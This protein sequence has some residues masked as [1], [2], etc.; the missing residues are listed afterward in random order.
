MLFINYRCEIQLLQGAQLK[1]G[2]ESARSRGQAT[3]LRYRWGIPIKR[4]AASRAA[5][6]RCSILLLQ[7]EGC[8]S[9][10]II[11]ST[12]AHH[13]LFFKDGE[14]RSPLSLGLMESIAY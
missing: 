2:T 13:L 11:V 12:H 3:C 1:Q 10:F 14:F 5:L 4:R 8:C 9:T 7:E 6:V